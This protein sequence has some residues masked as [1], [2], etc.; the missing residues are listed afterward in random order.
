MEKRLTSIIVVASLSL[1]ACDLL[2]VHRVD[3][4]QGNALQ[5]E[6]VAKVEEGM[7]RDQVRFLLGTP[8]LNDPFH[9]GRW[10]YIYYL[11]PG[12]GI[13]E[14]RRLTVYFEDDRVIRLEKALNG[15]ADGG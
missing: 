1:A 13:E 2:S 9:A 7:T 3:V 14:R 10:D 15:A 11:N 8:L 5:P 6:T 12:G 4:Q